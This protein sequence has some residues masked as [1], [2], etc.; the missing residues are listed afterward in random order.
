MRKMRVALLIVMAMMVVFTCA[1][2]KSK[3][4]RALEALQ[5]AFDF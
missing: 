2:C 4:E 5:D 3:E 1:S